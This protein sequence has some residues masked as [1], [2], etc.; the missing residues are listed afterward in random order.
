M[1][2]LYC[3][4]ACRCRVAWCQARL[5]ILIRIELHRPLTQLSF[6]YSHPDVNIDVAIRDVLVCQFDCAKFPCTIFMIPSL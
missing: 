6:L 4:K 5:D 2:S 1:T 3:H